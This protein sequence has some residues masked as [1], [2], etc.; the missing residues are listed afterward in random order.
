MWED[1]IVAEVHRARVKLAA[2]CN[3]DIRTFFAG[4][5]ERQAAM[6][7]QREQA[8]PTAEASRQNTLTNSW[9]H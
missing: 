3:Y 2:E 6:L 1:P 4:L 7:A 8:E 9:E 5:G